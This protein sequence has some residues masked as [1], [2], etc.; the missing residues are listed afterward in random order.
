[1]QIP[2]WLLCGFTRSPAYKIYKILYGDKILDLP[3][4]YLDAELL[5][6]NADQIDDIDGIDLQIVDDMALRL[7]L[8]WIDTDILADNLCYTRKHIIALPVSG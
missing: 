7:N 4:G 3:V 2:A 6:K 1:M 5:L 8:G